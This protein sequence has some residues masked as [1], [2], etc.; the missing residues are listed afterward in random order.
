MTRLVRPRIPLDVKLTIILR[1]LGGMPGYVNDIVAEACASRRLGVKHDEALGRFANLTGCD[2][3]DLRLD[4]DPALENR[5][6]VFRKGVHVDYVPAANDP[7][8]LF[9]RPHGTQ[10][11][12]SHDVKT[13]I[14]GDRGQLPDNMIA[15]KNRNVAKRRARRA[16][17]KATGFQKRPFRVKRASESRSQAR[18]P[19][20]KWPSRPW[21]KGRKIGR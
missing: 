16:A 10:F 8:H 6:K 5:E 17:G 2:V 4:H 7:E 11:A 1:Q 12:G 9:Y 19:K 18:P 20:R 14:R 15:K 3:S 13:R 21:P